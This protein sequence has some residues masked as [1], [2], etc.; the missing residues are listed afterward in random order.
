MWSSG[1]PA[2]DSMFNTGWTNPGRVIRP[3]P[4]NR[5]S[6]RPVPGF[7]SSTGPPDSC[8]DRTGLADHDPPIAALIRAGQPPHGKFDVAAG[9]FTPAVHGAHIA[10]RGIAREKVPCLHSRLKAGQFECF[11]QETVRRLAPGGHSIGEITR[12]AN[13]FATPNIS[14]PGSGVRRRSLRRRWRR[15][16]QGDRATLHSTPQS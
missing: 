13:H 5:W 10:L 4:M 11:P 14:C 9:Q 6:A 7:I 2:R 16:N 15:P 1:V 8:S 3:A 12:T